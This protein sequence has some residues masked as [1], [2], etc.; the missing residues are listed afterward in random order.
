MPSR[1]RSV[2]LL[3]LMGTLAGSG[4]WA[5]GFSQPDQHAWAMG[6]GGAFAAR[7]TGAPALGYNVAGLAF[8]DRPELALGSAAQLAIT[9]FTG[10]DPFPGAL[11]EDPG[12]VVDV[13]GR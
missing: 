1:F 12:G 7:G 10:S 11:A 2:F 4:V 13:A 9:R 6:G 8:A 3:L 5:G